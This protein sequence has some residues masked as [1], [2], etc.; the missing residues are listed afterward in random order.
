M[1]PFI[2]ALHIISPL[3][4]ESRQAL[5]EIIDSKHYKKNSQLLRIGERAQR[6]FFIASGVGR[7]YYVKKGHDVTDYFATDNQFIGGVESLFTYQPSHKGVEVLEDSEVYALN[8]PGFEKLCHRYHDVE[9]VGRRLAVFAFLSIQRRV[10][11]I[12]FMTLRERYFEL[13][14]QHPGITNRVPLKH[15][16]S[17]LGTTQV[18][19][20]R[21]R[22]GK[23]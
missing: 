23:Q 22:A 5:G 3:S 10:E 8:Y 2:N 20:S 19:I 18:S 11:S 9:R 17:Y 4:D 21:I 6:F 15:I 7:V 13:E 16:A 14:T 1:N 12:R